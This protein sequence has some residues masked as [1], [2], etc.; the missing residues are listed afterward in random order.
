[1]ATAGAAVS[2]PARPDRPMLS[3]V[4]GLVVI[5]FCVGLNF[6]G[7]EATRKLD[8]LLFLDLVGTALASLVYGPII[9]ILVGFLTN[10][11]AELFG[12]Q[13]HYFLFAIVQAVSALFWGAAPR[14]LHGRALTDFF[15]DDADQRHSY[16]Y[17]HLFWGIIW[18]SLASH[19]L[20]S[21]TIGVLMHFDPSLSCSKLAEGDPDRV[22]CNVD[23]TMFGA[24]GNDAT[25]GIWQLTLAKALLGWPDHLLAVSFAVL[26]AAHLL[27][28]R[29]YKMNMAFDSDVAIQNWIVKIVS[30]LL[31]GLFVFEVAQGLAKP[32]QNSLPW[33]VYIVGLFLALLL[34]GRVLSFAVG[35]TKECYAKINPD[36]EHAFEDSLRL[37]MVLSVIVY[38]VVS[39]ICGQGCTIFGSVQDDKVTG[40]VGVAFIIITFRY[41]SIIIA[42]S[43][44]PLR[45]FLQD[46]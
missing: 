36:L 17:S 46:V 7:I 13:E 32:L 20:A 24:P 30:I 14:I 35:A 40:V 15:N 45:R 39:G 26:M 42:R 41:V 22:L 43:S 1:M 18:F 11:I 16:D 10:G 3:V 21:F 37:G 12:N 25:Y 29:R 19:L 33:I 6:A 23:A 9:G 5:A 44:R 38:Y 28:K 31:F 34:P 2:G 27:P 4:R 8:S